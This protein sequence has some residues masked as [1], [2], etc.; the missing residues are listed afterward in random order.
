MKTFPTIL[1]YTCYT[2]GEQ[3]SNASHDRDEVMTEKPKI[4]E[5]WNYPVKLDFLWN[6]V[7]FSHLSYMINYII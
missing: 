3:T 1:K 6:V 5:K 2:G 7:G 4:K